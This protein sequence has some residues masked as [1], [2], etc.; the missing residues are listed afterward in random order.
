M[1]WTP[2]E[3]LAAACAALVGP[4]AVTDGYHGK[5][6]DVDGDDLVVRFGWRRHPRQFRVGFPLDDP[7]HGAGPGCRP[8]RPASEWVNEVSGV[9]M[10][11]LDTGAAQWALRR[12][13]NGTI[14]PELSAG[15]PDRSA[16]YVGEARAKPLGGWP[17]IDWT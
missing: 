3:L 12:E 5:A 11:D 17:S 13:S 2:E 9:L 4:D 8:A 1:A 15:P 10:E 6:V 14:E 7:D 16:Y